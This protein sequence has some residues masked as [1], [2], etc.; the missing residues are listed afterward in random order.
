MDSGRGYLQKAF[1]LCFGRN[2]LASS[3]RKPG[4]HGYLCGQLGN[5]DLRAAR[6]EKLGQG[7]VETSAGAC[8]VKERSRGT[9]N[10][11]IM[12]FNSLLAPASRFECLQV[13]ASIYF[14]RSVLYF[15]IN[16]HGIVNIV[17][18]GLI[19]AVTL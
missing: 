12:D 16:A 10:L 9:Y 4:G 7:S 11:K 6:A 3:E 13:V 18:L 15:P 17:H 8:Y 2:H 19:T 1:G 5:R 14:H